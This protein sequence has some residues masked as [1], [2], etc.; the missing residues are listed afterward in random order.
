M[1]A[2]IIVKK[3][4]IHK[5]T[6]EII[7]INSDLQPYPQDRPLTNVKITNI[8]VTATYRFHVE[9]FPTNERDLTSNCCPN[10]YFTVLI[11][12]SINDKLVDM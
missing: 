10:S 7:P 6:S 4:G 5:I 8:Q 2:Q 1:W 9:S 11:K 12:A 3:S